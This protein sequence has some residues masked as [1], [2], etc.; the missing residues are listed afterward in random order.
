MNH[1][2]IIVIHP[3]LKKSRLDKEYFLEE[4]INLVKAINLNCI[5]SS[6]AGLQNINTKTYLNFGY[7]NNLRKLFK[8][9]RLIWY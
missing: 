7:I 4:A 3:Y 1:K 5:Y 2:D 9:I 6:Y 8:K